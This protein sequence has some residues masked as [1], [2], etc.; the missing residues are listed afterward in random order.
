MAAPPD[1]FHDEVSYDPYDYA[2]HE[3]P[4]PTYRRLRAE[5]PLYRNDELDFWAISRHADVAAAFR[6]HE[7]YSSANG[8]SLDPSAWGPG[9]APH[10]VVPGHGPAR[11]HPHA[12]PGLEGLHATAGP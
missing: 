11:A 8:V 10:D 5:A 6:D 4:Y 2:I 9:R 1:A 7:R 12:R 3:D